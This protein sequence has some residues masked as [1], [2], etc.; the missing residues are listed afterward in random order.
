MVL[1]GCSH[2]T[3]Q[4]ACGT[5][6]TTIG[7]LESKDMDGMTRRGK[8]YNNFNLCYLEISYQ[9]NIIYII[10]IIEMDS[11]KKWADGPFK[12]LSTPRASLEVLY[13]SKNMTYKVI[14]DIKCL[15]EDRAKQN[16]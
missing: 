1:F 6:K 8:E 16:L 11:T 3:N 15:L 9:H 2:A 12:L 4:L 7:Q 5:L 10:S 13:T 14:R